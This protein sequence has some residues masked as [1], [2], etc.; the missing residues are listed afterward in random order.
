MRS[1]CLL[2]DR[3]L[4]GTAIEN[5]IRNAHYGEIVRYSNYAEIP[6]SIQPDSVYFL[7]VHLVPVDAAI[8]SSREKVVTLVYGE[9]FTANCIHWWMDRGATVVW[10]LKDS[11][12]DI[13]GRIPNASEAEPVLSPSAEKVLRSADRKVGM[14]RLSKKELQVAKRLVLGNSTRDVAKELGVTEG[15]IKNQRKSVYRKLGIVRSS[16]LPHAM[17][18]GFAH[19]H[20]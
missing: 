7:A 1:V 9:G 5:C 19:L 16:Q 4:L 3:P 12:D 8:P 14:H 18:N 10:D 11:L 2:E 6:K 17:G 15:T 20:K 13:L